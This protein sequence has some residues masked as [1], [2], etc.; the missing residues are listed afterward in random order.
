MICFDRPGAV[1]A[2]KMPSLSLEAMAIGP[3][4]STAL[5]TASCRLRVHSVFSSTVN[6]AVEGSDILVSLTG[7]R[8]AVYPQA[9]AVRHSRDFCT[10]PLAIGDRGRLAAASL[11]LNTKAGSFTVD[12]RAAVRTGRRD[13]TVITDLDKGGA[14]RAVLGRLIDIQT[15]QSSDLRVDEVMGREGGSE[16]AVT[17][18][19]AALCR[20][21]GALFREAR[22]GALMAQIHGSFSRHVSALMGAG[23][24]LTPSGDDFICGFLAAT[25]AAGP[26]VA[27]RRLAA[28][29]ADFAMRESIKERIASTGEISA[30][31]L[32]MAMLG[33]WPGPLVDIVQGLAAGDRC[34]V[35]AALDELCAFGHS[36]G[37]D[38]ATGFLSGLYAFLWREPALC[39]A[40]GARNDAAG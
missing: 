5:S 22:S 4:A 27:R 25:S 17:S 9:V 35:L 7:P 37:A 32:R 24:G 40:G 19:G 18:L 15:A 6:L 28:K 20:L 16:S 1:P 8:G 3:A 10:L 13:L 31:F 12:L 38:I 21:G 34:S 11:Q 29:Q 26:L 39:L 23:R 14:F 36:S 30:S 2:E 33:F